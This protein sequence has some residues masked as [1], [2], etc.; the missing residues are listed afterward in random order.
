M[1]PSQ[2]VVD[3]LQII[4]KQ[5]LL[6][7]FAQ[8]KSAVSKEYGFF[9]HMYIHNANIHTQTHTHTPGVHTQQ[10]RQGNRQAQDKNSL[11]KK[12]PILATWQNWSRK[13][14][15]TQKALEQLSC[16]PER[17]VGQGGSAGTQHTRVQSHT[18]WNS[19]SISR[20]SSVG[21]DSLIKGRHNS[22]VLPIRVTA[23]LLV[24]RFR[25]ILRMVFRPAVGI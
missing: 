15:S 20:S 12:Q 3:V 25:S 16:C 2:I 11:P 14:T 9:T 22:T 23:A 19:T 21:P 8:Q 7:L 6:H 4:L 10:N 18:R 13:N 17:K 5:G 1:D 24:S